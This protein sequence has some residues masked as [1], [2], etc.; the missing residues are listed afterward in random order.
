MSRRVERLD[1]TGSAGR[2][3]AVLAWPA[4]PPL[5][6]AL[7]CH[8]HPLFGGSMHTK[9]VYRTARALVG[10]GVATLRFNFRGV[11]K[12]DGSFSGGAGE[13]EDAGVALAHVAHRVGRVPLLLG[14]FS[15]GA[16]VAL[17]LGAAGSAG[18]AVRA[19]LGIAPALS[20]F[21]FDFLVQTC[22]PILFVAGSADPYCPTADL[23]ALTARLG[24]RARAVIL[25]GA[26]HLLLE[27]LP[28]L[29]ETVHHFAADVFA[30]PPA[31]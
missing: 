11:G 8:P 22:A 2:L 14:G 4:T 10:T 13:L 5:G 26:G 3:E 16:L 17:Q 21:E 12:S 19:L 7:V 27:R 9:A 6:A 28:E 31:A 18:L 29:E 20:L 1:L 25:P 24:P 15:F 23:E 30:Q